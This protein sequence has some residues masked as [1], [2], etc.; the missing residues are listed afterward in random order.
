MFYKN[1]YYGIVAQ[2]VGIIFS[3]KK[4]KLVCISSIYIYIYYFLTYICH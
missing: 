1:F 3:L 4:K 2:L